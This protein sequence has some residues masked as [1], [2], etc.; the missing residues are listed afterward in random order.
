MKYTNYIKKKANISKSIYC[1]FGRED[2]VFKTLN[3]NQILKAII[4]F[5]IIYFFDG[6]LYTKVCEKFQSH[7]DIKI[8]KPLSCNKDIFVN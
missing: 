6:Y 8:P 1:Q 3:K 2:Q 7:K 4:L 5:Y